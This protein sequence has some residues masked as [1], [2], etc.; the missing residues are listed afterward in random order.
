MHAAAPACDTGDTVSTG[1]GGGA[2]VVP[3][4]ITG[5]PRGEKRR[6]NDDYTVRNDDLL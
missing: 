5:H 1:I 4:H 3:Q 6:R 2:S